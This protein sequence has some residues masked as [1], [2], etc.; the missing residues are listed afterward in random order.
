MRR[1]RA[2]LLPGPVPEQDIDCGTY[3]SQF[4][5]AA[6]AD[7]TVAMD[8]VDSAL[9]HLFLVQYRLGMFDSPASVP[10]TN[11]STSVVCSPEHTAL[12]LEAARE[13]IVLLKNDGALPLDAAVVKTLAVIGPNGVDA[14]HRALQAAFHNRCWALCVC[15]FSLS[16]P[17]HS[18][19]AFPFPPLVPHPLPPPCPNAHLQLT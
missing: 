19:F 2:L 1:A 16:F 6:I 7:G 8:L 13:G 17:P 10:F 18:S 15:V 3:L 14:V 5:P 12:A 11:I 4:L 9:T